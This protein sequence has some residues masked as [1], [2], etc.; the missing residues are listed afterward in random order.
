[1]LYSFFV[2]PIELLNVYRQTCI[3]MLRMNSHVDI[4]HNVIQSSVTNMHPRILENRY[5]S[6]T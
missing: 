4:F 1:M 6:W 2:C 5:F 3:V